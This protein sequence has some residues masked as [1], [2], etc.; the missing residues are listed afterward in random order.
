M[1]TTTTAATPVCCRCGR[2]HKSWRAVALCRWPK[3]IWIAGNPPFDGPCYASVS[4]CPGFRRSGPTV[5][6]YRTEARAMEGK[7]L[8]DGLGCGGGCCRMHKVERMT[9]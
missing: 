1:T 2:R 6:L 3:A 5:I 8:I 7:K 9:K 4:S